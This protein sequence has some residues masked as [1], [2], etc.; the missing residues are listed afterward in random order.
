MADEPGFIWRATTDFRVQPT[1]FGHAWYWGGDSDRETLVIP[2]G[3]RFATPTLTY[4]P[5]PAGAYVFATGDEMPEMW[6]G[7]TL[8]DPAGSLEVGAVV[9]AKASSSGITPPIS[10]FRK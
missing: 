9:T 6:M 1:G 5:S 8:L 3:T 7:W 4:S 10:A 2:A